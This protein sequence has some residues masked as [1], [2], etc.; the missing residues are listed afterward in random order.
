MD[1]FLGSG[2]TAMACKK[3]NRNFLCNELNKE[4]FN[5]ALKKLKG[6]EQD[7][8]IDFTY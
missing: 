5:L 3:L 7:I 8:K 6:Y 4:Y 1:M 2:T